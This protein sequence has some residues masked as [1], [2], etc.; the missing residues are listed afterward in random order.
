MFLIWAQVYYMQHIYRLLN[1]QTLQAIFLTIDIQLLETK[2]IIY[3]VIG[4]VQTKLDI[5]KLFFFLFI[6][7]LKHSER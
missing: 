3:T 5:V 4:T 6:L 7:Q 2:E 1:S